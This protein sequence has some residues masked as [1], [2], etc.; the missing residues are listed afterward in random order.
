MVGPYTG[1][2]CRMEGNENFGMF[3]YIG[4][5]NHLPINQLPDVDTIGG[6]DDRFKVVGYD[7]TTGRIGSLTESR[8][9]TDV[10]VVLYDNNSRVDYNRKLGNWIKI[11]YDGK[12]DNSDNYSIMDVSDDF[13][14]GETS[15]KYIFVFEDGRTQEMIVGQTYEEYGFVDT[16]FEGVWRGTNAGPNSSVVKPFNSSHT[17]SVQ[18][19]EDE[20]YYIFSC[21][22]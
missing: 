4:G 14:P 17:V 7:F 2:L 8:T 11:Y 20:G 12:A 13:S 6:E 16:P 1:Y 9:C 10:E 22:R 21:W 15:A 3:L 19:D 5:T 18:Y